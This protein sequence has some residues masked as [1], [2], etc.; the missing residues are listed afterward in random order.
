[1]IGCSGI[2]LSVGSPYSTSLTTF[3][4]FPLPEESKL[5]RTALMV[6][7]NLTFIFPLLFPWFPVMLAVFAIL[8]EQCLEDSAYGHTSV[9]LLLLHLVFPR[10]SFARYCTCR[11]L[12]A[13][14][15]ADT[16]CTVFWPDILFAHFRLGKNND[17]FF[18]NSYKEEQKF[19]VCNF[20]VRFVLY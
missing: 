9:L 11:S 13:P 2:P 19:I 16:N 15:K 6:L 12:T 7:H 8:S 14:P 20:I 5:F 1:M 17:F 4:A 3:L 18:V 10:M